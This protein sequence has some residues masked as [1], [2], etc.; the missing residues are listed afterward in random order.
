MRPTAP[1]FPRSTHRSSILSRPSGRRSEP[2]IQNATVVLGGSIVIETANLPAAAPERPADLAPGDFVRISVADTGTGM[3]EE[4]LA[5]AF[6]PFFS[7][8]EPGKGTGLGL[9]QVYGVVKQLGGDVRIRSRLGEG[10]IVD[11]Y[12][13]RAAAAALR[14]ADSRAAESALSP[15]RATIVI[16]DDDP[17]VREFI[18]N[19]LERLG[20]KVQASS[21]A[22]LALELIDRTGADLLVADLAMPEI[23]GL[24]LA[25]AARARRPDLPIVFISGYSEQVMANE[26]EMGDGILKKPFKLAELAHAIETARLR[27]APA[28]LASGDNII[29]LRTR[30]ASFEE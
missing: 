18:A 22:L 20:Y 19:G 30:T 26:L 11:V 16:V 28:A 24:E 8:K 1:M 3:S 14:R 13:P 15:T 27:E 2:L 4:V 29:P 21:S 17:D 6:E 9:A 25:R 5:K 10:T 12:L 7:T 23:T